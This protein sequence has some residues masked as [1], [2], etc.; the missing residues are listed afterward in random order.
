MFCFYKVL[1]LYL[2]LNLVM[3]L[4]CNSRLQFISPKKE[5][6]QNSYSQLWL[7]L[8]GSGELFGHKL[9]KAMVIYVYYLWPD[10]SIW[11][12]S[13]TLQH[14]T[15]PL[16]FHFKKYLLWYCFVSLLIHQLYAFNGR[17][18]HRKIGNCNIPLC[19]Y[20]KESLSFLPKDFWGTFIFLVNLGLKQQ[21]QQR[22]V[23]GE[24][25]VVSP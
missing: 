11:F 25:K 10:L 18:L 23:C 16:L 22:K 2:G 5:I 24:E 4:I 8:M 13:A 21:T 17:K 12:S 9:S 15:L 7:Y 19:T 14:S 6:L 1:N 20:M 3:H